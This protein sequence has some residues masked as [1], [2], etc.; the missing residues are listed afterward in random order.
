MDVHGPCHL[1][2][3]N[4]R[5]KGKTDRKRETAKIVEKKGKKRLCGQR[6]KLLYM[7]MLFKKK[8]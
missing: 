7:S 5:E 3:N 8:Y 2:R 6:G 4:D 1:K